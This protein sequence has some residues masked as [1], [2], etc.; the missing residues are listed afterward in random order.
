MKDHTEQAN[1]A[2]INTL[3]TAA[4]EK[5]ILKTQLQKLSNQMTTI[6]NLMAQL[7]IRDTEIKKP[8]EENMG[9]K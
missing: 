8:K 6:T 3:D 1:D 9:Q 7:K 5:D 4:D 2:L